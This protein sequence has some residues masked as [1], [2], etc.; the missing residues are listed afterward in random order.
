VKFKK[1]AIGFVIAFS[2]ALALNAVS[3]TPPRGNDPTTN[4]QQ[5]FLFT[6]ANEP[7][8]R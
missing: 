5:T 1:L 8:A 7:V 6:S 3:K 2:A 4:E